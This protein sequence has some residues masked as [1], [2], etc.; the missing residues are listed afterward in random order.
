MIENV[1]QRIL[2]IWQGAKNHYLT[3]RFVLFLKETGISKVVKLAIF[4]F[5][6][7]SLRKHPSESMLAAREFYH[8]NQERLNA[9]MNMLADDKSRI[10]LGGVLSY[11]TDRTPISKKNYSSKDQYFVE[12]IIHVDQN[13]VFIDG[14]AYTGDTIRE[15]L[16]IVKKQK[17][18][19]K[20]IIAFEPNEM[21]YKMLQKNYGRLK[22]IELIKKGLSDKE[23]VL[24]FQEFG[25]ASKVTKNEKE[26]TT[27]IPVINIDNVP[28]CKDATWI[29]MDIEGSELDALHGAKETILR[30]HPKLTICIYHSNE[31]MLGIAEYIHKIVPEYKLYIRHHTNCSEETV[32]YAIM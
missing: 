14:G 22:H 11:L 17:Q 28:A 6:D 27:R 5:R 10:V 1:L 32:L 15:L 16:K 8:E 24:L 26:A 29:K 30:N 12:D 31:H 25:N 4:Y 18:K 23:G 3:F 2:Q 13:E 21:N 19:I 9:V 7:R 20:K